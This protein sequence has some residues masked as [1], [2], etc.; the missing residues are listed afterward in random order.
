MNSTIKRL[1]AEAGIYDGRESLYWCG[2]DNLER[3]S[4]LII[5]ECID[6]CYCYRYYSVEG[7]AQNIV[8]DIKEHFGVEE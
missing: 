7:M 1:C 6:I 4:E 2:E 8:K 3:F 5:K